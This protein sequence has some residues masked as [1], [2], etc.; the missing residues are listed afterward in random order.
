MHNT[1]PISLCL[2]AL[3]RFRGHTFSTP[4]TILSSKRCSSHLP[5]HGRQQTPVDCID[6]THG[7]PH[8]RPDKRQSVRRSVQGLDLGRNIS[9]VTDPLLQV[10]LDRRQVVGG[11]GRVAGSY[12]DDFD[13][14]S[15]GRR[16]AHDFGEPHAAER[17]PHQQG[18]ENMPHLGHRRAVSNGSDQVPA[19]SVGNHLRTADTQVAMLRCRGVHVQIFDEPQQVPK[20]QC[21]VFM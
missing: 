8:V 11:Q 14:P 1:H 2:A 13:A 5:V 18:K 6:R 12:P 19:A 9:K 4:T 21:A 17:N 15:P 7:Q 16:S 10:A 3:F 20:R